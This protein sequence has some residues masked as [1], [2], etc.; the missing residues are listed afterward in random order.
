MDPLLVAGL[1][2]VAPPLMIVVLPA[3]LTGLVLMASPM[4][5]NVVGQARAHRLE[6]H[7]RLA[8]RGP[9]DHQHEP[10]AP[11]RSLQPTAAVPPHNGGV[12]AT[13]ASTACTAAAA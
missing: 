11:H 7:P 1:T 5:I 12:R 6:R 4:I 3:L 9:S 2:F 13:T 10:P 8:R